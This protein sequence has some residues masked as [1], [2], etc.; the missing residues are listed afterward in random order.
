MFK[1]KFY[2]ILILSLAAS[3]ITAFGFA[4]TLNGEFRLEDLELPMVLE[5]AS[6]SAIING[7]LFSPIAY[8][9]LKYQDLLIIFPILCIVLLSI[10]F[11]T[12][13]IGIEARFKLLIIYIYWISALLS[14]KKFNMLMSNS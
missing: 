9:C 3:F 14:I 8:W 13:H 10:I 11:L 2:I 1:N 6:I 5:L 7:L 4:T 12:T